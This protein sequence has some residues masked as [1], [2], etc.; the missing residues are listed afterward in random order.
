MRQ[1]VSLETRSALF[2]WSVLAIATC[3]LIALGE[4]DTGA[5][6]ATGIQSEE[7][8]AL[9]YSQH[10]ARCHGASGNGGP[11][12]S[13][14]GRAPALR[15]EV[16]PDITVAYLDLVMAT[17]R[18]PPAASPY[19]NRTRNVIFDEQER[20]EIIAWMG[21][22]FGVEGGLPDAAE[23]NAAHGQE[24]WNANC[25]HCHGATGA[26]G[27]AGA[28]A[29]TPSVRAQPAEI[30]AEAIRVGPFQMP[31]FR[32]T[33]ISDE[34]ISDVVAFLDE[35][36]EEPRTPIL[37]LVELNPVYASAY[38]AGL[39]LLVVVSLVWIGGRP[40]WFPDPEQPETPEVPAG[41]KPKGADPQEA[42]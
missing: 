15:P 9:L 36:G 30:I 24:V 18:M 11:M 23:G 26:G 22:E 40:A 5:Q 41:A 28:G 20:A 4:R 8:G 29:W 39:A 13:Y 31:Q 21:A 16:N 25:A 42:S 33:Q 3:A 2:G 7:R 6:A 10:C 17:G 38:V 19:D 14:E 34:E 1:A 35:V 12:E 27:V 32:D 37:G